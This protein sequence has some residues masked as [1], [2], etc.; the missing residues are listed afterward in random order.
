MLEF[1]FL[2]SFF[3]LIFLVYT[4]LYPVTRKYMGYRRERE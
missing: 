1:L 4:Q 3:F 2:V